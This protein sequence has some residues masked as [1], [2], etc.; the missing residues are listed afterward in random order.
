MNDWF[1]VNQ[2]RL[3]TSAV[4]KDWKEKLIST[5]GDNNWK[6]IRYAYLYKFT[7]GC[8]IDYCVK[9]EKILLELDRK[10][11]DIVILDL[12]IVGLPSHV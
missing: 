7:F 2:R 4:W 11:L 3:E 8:Y 5:F 6:P 1:L 9:K 10:L 12:I